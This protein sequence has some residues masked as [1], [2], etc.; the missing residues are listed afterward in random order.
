MTSPSRSWCRKGRGGEGFGHEFVERCRVQVRAD[1]DG[2]FLIRGI[3]QS[4]ETFSGVLGNRKKPDVIDDHQISPQDTGY[5][6]GHG[7]IGAVAA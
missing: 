6:F 3:D 2:A 5:R 4:V 1:R 7:V